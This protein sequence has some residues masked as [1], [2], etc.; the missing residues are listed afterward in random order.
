MK[1][2]GEDT[3]KRRISRFMTL[4]ASL[5]NYRVIGIVISPG[6]IDH[7]GVMYIPAGESKQLDDKPVLP[8]RIVKSASPSELTIDKERVKDY[9]VGGVIKSVRSKLKE[10]EPVRGGASSSHDT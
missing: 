8:G 4:S 9:T 3:N 1:N 10:T 5:R 6:G 2:S 7:P